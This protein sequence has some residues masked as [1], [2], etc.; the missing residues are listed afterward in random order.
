MHPNLVKVKV[1]T[2]YDLST[3][4]LSIVLLNGSTWSWAHP[5][6]DCQSQPRVLSFVAVLVHDEHCNFLRCKHA[7]KKKFICAERSNHQ[8]LLL[9]K[10]Q[11]SVAWVSKKKGQTAC[12]HSWRQ[13]VEILPFG[14]AGR[15]SADGSTGGKEMSRVPHL[16]YM[17][18][19]RLPVTHG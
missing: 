1:G 15:K 3:L 12:A 8:L 10:L 4:T 19:C 16:G 6:R 14:T 13:Y 2:F 9:N 17:T 11:V 5:N 18:P 7:F